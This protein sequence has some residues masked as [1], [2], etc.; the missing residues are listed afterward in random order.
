VAEN[1]TKPTAVDVS[2]FIDAVPDSKRRE[3]AK[4]LCALM[5][6][7]IG[8]PPKMW[9]PS[10]I[11]F[12]RYRYRYE[13]GR[14]GEAGVAGF[15]PRARELVLYL[16]ADPPDKE[17]LLARLG[18]HKTGKCCLYIKSLADVDAGVLEQL[19]V[20]AARTIKERYPD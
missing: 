3:D 14:E 13:S 4:A 6:R 2:A 12:G 9:G 1:K 20:G 19:V 15:S 11:G 7:V 18:K 10:I 16:P 5:E 8:E 17:A